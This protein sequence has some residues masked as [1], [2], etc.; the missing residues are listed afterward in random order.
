MKKTIAII[1]ALVCLGTLC[2]CAK[3]EEKVSYE[4]SQEQIDL[5]E[6]A[7]EGRTVFYGECHDHC[8]TGGNSDGKKTLTEY[9][10]EMERLGIDFS[11]VLDHNQSAHMYLNEW[12]NA[13]FLG[14]TEMGSTI[15]DST[16]PVKGMHYSLVFTDPQALNSILSINPLYEFDPETNLCV[17]VNYKIAEMKA[18]IQ[19]VKDAGGMW[20]QN[21]PMGNE[22]GGYLHSENPMDNWFADGTGIDVMCAYGGHSVESVETKENYKLWTGILKAG[23]RVW[24]TAI[25]DLHNLPTTNALTAVY[26]EEKTP[27]S[28]FSQMRVG[29]LNGGYCGIRMTIGDAR[30]G[31]LGTSFTDQTVIFSVGDFHESIFEKYTEF[32]VVLLDDEGEVFRTTIDHTKTNYFAYP[33]DPTVSFYR[34]EVQNLAGDV[35]ALGNP[36][37]RE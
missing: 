36:I 18:L 26:A 33:C 15:L 31:N 3:G 28:I 5:L 22:G 27:E 9:A 13:C 10:A 32:Q 20:V 30:M 14:G 6:K 7:Y 25:G 34:V 8:N 1:L 21:H 37:W 19:K 4:A 24:A 11:N 16:C 29:E 35:V 17:P 23:G 12:N 2:A